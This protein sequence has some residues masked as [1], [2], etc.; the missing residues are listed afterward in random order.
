M[1]WGAWALTWP[2]YGLGVLHVGMGYSYILITVKDRQHK[3]TDVNRLEE[4]NQK[5]VS[6][7]LSAASQDDIAKMTLSSASAT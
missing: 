6:L 4:E 3:T 7:P 1:G 5:S 2:H